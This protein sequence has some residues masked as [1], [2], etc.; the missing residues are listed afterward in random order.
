MSWLILERLVIRQSSSDSPSNA[1]LPRRPIVL[2][3]T[4]TEADSLYR[5]AI[6]IGERSLGSDH[7][8]LGIW[9][10]NRACL[11]KSQVGR[12][13]FVGIQQVARYMMPVQSSHRK[14]NRTGTRHYS[15]FGLVLF[16]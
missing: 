6:E 2:Q 13:Q 9:L 11:F 4:Y 7:P 16:R 3:G 12:L 14:R 1:A 10:N 5:R 8:D 15:E